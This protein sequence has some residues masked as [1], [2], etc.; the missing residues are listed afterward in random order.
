MQQLLP[1]AKYSAAAAAE[2]SVLAQQAGG[3]ATS[4]Y[5]TLKEWVDKNTESTKQFNKQTALEEGAIT[6][7]TKVAESFA[8]TLDSSVAAALQTATISSAQLTQK[9]E[10]L[11]TAWSQA[12]NTVAGPVVGAFR[13]LVESL[14]Q[15]YGNTK[16]AIGVADA[17]MRQ[18][19]ATAGQVANLN[20]QIASTVAWLSRIHSPPP[21]TI[22]VNGQITASGQAAIAASG[23]P[24]FGHGGVGHAVQP[25]AQTGAEYAAAGVTLVGEQGPEL[26]RFGGGEQV[27][28]SWQTAGIMHGAGGGGEGTINLQSH[29]VINVSGAKIGSAT[30]TQVLVLP[31]Q[32]PVQQLVLAD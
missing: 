18:Q 6:D 7:A 29:N 26:V 14:T 17:Y 12:H 28:P 25:G 24:G 9:A 11:N 10:D 22:T 27:V 19:G 4:S 31:A 13:Q 15:V 30:R 1:Y 2:L 23:N 5:K 16:T 20:R 3:P 32:K 8:S 21:V